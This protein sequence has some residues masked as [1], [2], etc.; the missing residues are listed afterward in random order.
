L[1]APVSISPGLHLAVDSS[2]FTLISQVRRMSE[3]PAEEALTVDVEKD[4][5][6]NKDDDG[7]L[8]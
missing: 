7:E 4:D 6:F 8:T 5:D 3:Q 1:I 2:I